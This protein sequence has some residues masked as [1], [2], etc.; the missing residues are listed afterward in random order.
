LR[1]EELENEKDA[2]FRVQKRQELAQGYRNT[3]ARG[4]GGGGAGGVKVRPVEM[5]L[6]G[7]KS[8]YAFHSPG[9]AWRWLDETYGDGAAAESYWWSVWLQRVKEFLCTAKLT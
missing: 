6:R 2:D 5:R 9:E 3:G 1:Q 8:V 7:E 4:G